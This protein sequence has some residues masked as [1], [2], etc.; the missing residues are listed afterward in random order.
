[1]ECYCL[2]VDSIAFSLP[3]GFASL[4]TYLGYRELCFEMFLQ[5]V[6]NHI[7]ELPIDIMKTIINGKIGLSEKEFDSIKFS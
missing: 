5:Y 2:A 1:L 6:K 7:F 4:C 3:Q